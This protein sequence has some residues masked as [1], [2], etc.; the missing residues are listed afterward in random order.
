MNKKT[1]RRRQINCGPLPQL[2]LQYKDF[3]GLGNDIVTAMAEISATF[4]NIL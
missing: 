2:Q 1:P 4:V 3:R